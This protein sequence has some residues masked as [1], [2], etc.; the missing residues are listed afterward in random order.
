VVYSPGLASS[1]FVSLYLMEHLASWGFVVITMDHFDTA[2]VDYV[3]E[4]QA[5]FADEI[6]LAQ[7]KRPAQTRRVLDCAEALTAEGGDFAGVIDLDEVAVVGHS[8]GGWNAFA[9]AG[10]RMHFDLL[11]DW[12]AQGTYASI[13]VTLVCNMASQGT[14]DE[15]EGRL[16]SLAGVD[17]QPGA[18]W[19]SLGDPRVDAIVPI[20][21]GGMLTFGE[22]GL[23]GVTVPTLILF[24]SAD[25]TAIPEFNAR[26]AY[27]R[28]GSKHKGQVIFEDGGHMMFAQCNAA[29]TSTAFQMCSDPVWDLMRV[30]DLTNHF[31]TAFLL[32]E[33]YGDADAAAA[34]AS[35]A[36]QFPGITYETTGF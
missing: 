30:H 35:D 8:L 13:L 34:L 23:Q 36:V 1:R 5:T 22:D 4:D 6:F 19:P 24:G 28:L 11:N 32:A 29:W 27:E 18:L 15:N 25:M 33:L 9:V 10:A 16:I 20:A 12:C 31:T 7:A 17:I 3:A 26:W 14:L 21:P 2:L